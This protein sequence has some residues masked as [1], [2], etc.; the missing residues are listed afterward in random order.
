[1]AELDV[2]IVE[3]LWNRLISVAEEQ[4]RALHRGSFSTTVSEVEDFCSTLH[5]PVGRMIAQSPSTGTISMLTGHARSI[6]VLA[7]MF[8]DRVEPGDAIISNDPWLLAGHKWD[9]TL[10]SPVFMNHRLVAW[11]ATALHVADIGGRGFTTASQ[12]TFEEGLTIPALKLMRAGHPNPDVFDLIA[13]NVRMPEQVIGDLKAQVAANC[14]GVSAIQ[15]LL[16]E[17]ELEDLGGIGGEIIGRSERAFRQAMAA[18]PAGVYRHS[19]DL[20]GFDEPLRVACTLTVDGTGI[21]ADFAGTSPQVDRAINAVGYVAYG[22]VAHALKSAIAPA[23]PNNEGVFRPITVTAPEGSL[24]NARRPA[25]TAARH[26][27]HFFLSAAVFGCLAQMNP[28]PPG[29]LADSGAGILH[30]IRG[31]REDGR[32]FEFWF[33]FSH[34]MGATSRMDGY[35]GTCA[36]NNVASTPVELLEARTPVF[37]LRKELVPDSGGPGRFRGGH[38]QEY[39][40]RVRSATPVSLSLMFDRTRHPPLGYLGGWNGETAKVCVNDQE[41]HPKGTYTITSTDVVRVVGPGGGGFFP[42]EERAPEAV[43]EDVLNG[44][45]SPERA[46][47]HYRVGLRKDG[48]SVDAACTAVLR[49]TPRERRAE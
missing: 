3:I 35:S 39:V 37:F 42:P 34:G 46:R 7:E 19:V 9:V 22:R 2:R 1:M 44:V 18:L 24:V 14:V 28:S 5:D 4:A 33:A 26:V 15:A 30:T 23:I 32:S 31:K 13:A 21:R 41:V 48:C 36:P 16:A 40:F 29:V 43:L 20:D 6:R 45:V 11:S 27:L 8:A 17:Y 47:E 38:A 12:D 10:M 25:A 49:E